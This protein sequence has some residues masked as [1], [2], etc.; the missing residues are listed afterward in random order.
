MTSAEERPS[1]W[2]IRGHLLSSVDLAEDFARAEPQHAEAVAILSHQIRRI[3]I[4]LMTF[5]DET[6]IPA[7]LHVIMH[8]FTAAR[9]MVLILSDR[10]RE[11]SHSLTQLSDDLKRAQV[12]FIRKVRPGVD[13]T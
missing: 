3:K 8:G 13:Q 2:D 11:K 5:F 12:E 7:P 10:Y 9:E 1:I 4:E 6:P